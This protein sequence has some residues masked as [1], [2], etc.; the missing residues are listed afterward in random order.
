M[1]NQIERKCPVCGV[2]YYADPTRLKHGRQTTCGRAC[3]YK[4]RASGMQ[5]GT[6]HQCA[7]CGKPFYRATSQLKA[8][9]GAACC[10]NTCAHK[11]RQRVVEKPYV[12]VKTYDRTEAMKKAWQTRRSSGKA[13][14]DTSRDKARTNLI[15]NLQNLGGVSKFERKAAEVLRLLGFN[16]ASSV[17]ARNANG[18]FGCVFDLLIPER[19]LIV[20]CHG[21]Y[22]HG[23]RWTWDSPN[24][25][26]TK[27]LAYEER[28]R[29]A[30]LA[31]GFDLR[32]LWES[33]F[34]KDP[35]GALLAVVR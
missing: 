13:Y 21:N 19:R 23:G 18:T 16:A 20:E 10:S 28:K 31:M 35:C 6:E 7:S 26:Q 22:W 24:A 34:K 12:I 33:E 15:K 27:N 3:S 1:D 32:I 14:P 8:K 11:V 29:I 25:A 2:T 30:A 9:H 17:T 5:Q 4:L